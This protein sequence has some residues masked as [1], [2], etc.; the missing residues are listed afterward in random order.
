MKKLIKPLF[1]ILF[2]LAIG[3]NSYGQQY[4]P[5]QPPRRVVQPR[6]P[7]QVQR[8]PGQAQRY[9]GQQ[10]HYSGQAQRIPVQPHFSPYVRP[11]APA[12][13]VNVVPNA[14]AGGRVEVVKETFIGRQ[15]NLLPQQSRV[16]WPLYRRYVEDQT[17]IKIL[18]RQNSSANSPN[19]TL[20]LKRQ[21]ALE[22]QLVD[23]RQRYMNEFLKVLPPEKVSELY[24][25]E[26]AFND[27][28]LKQLSERSRTAGN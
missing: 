19:G 15:L 5:A 3:T 28:A 10:Q 4:Y 26:R 25:S 6:Y 20:Q 16:F 7:V 13:G 2:I 17:A 23:V 24:K 27:E 12:T 9:P 8:Y 21:L 18:I 14:G 22:A 11:Y 1:G